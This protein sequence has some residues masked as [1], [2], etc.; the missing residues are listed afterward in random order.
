MQPL[1][2]IEYFNNKRAL[3]CR[4]IATLIY[5]RFGLFHHKK[6]M[7]VSLLLSPC[8]CW[9]L[10]HNDLKICSYTQTPTEK[11]HPTFVIKNHGNICVAYFKYL[12]Y[13]HI[14]LGLWMF[15]SRFDTFSL[16][17]YFFDEV[18]VLRHLIVG[19]F[20]TL[21][22][23]GGILAKIVKPLFIEFQLTR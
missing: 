1:T 3:K 5:W 20:E 12:C 23:V 19:L 2:I 9:I 8:L 13:C 14:Y 22:I 7:K 11:T 15:R 4:P 6:G 18:W 10:M 16:V 17:V 21:N